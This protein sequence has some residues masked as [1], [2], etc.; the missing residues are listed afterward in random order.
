VVSLSH[1]LRA[2]CL[3]IFA[4]LEI[5]GCFVI[6]RHFRGLSGPV[7]NSILQQSR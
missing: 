3:S 7:S 2:L 5:F 4:D 6:F 1:M